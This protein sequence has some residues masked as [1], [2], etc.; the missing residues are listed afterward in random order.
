MSSERYELAQDDLEVALE[1]IRDTIERATSQGGGRKKGTLNPEDK[2]QLV[3]RYDHL[4]SLCIH[5]F[6]LNLYTRGPGHGKMDITY[7]I[8]SSYLKSI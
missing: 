3:T 5:C 1:E 7:F 4:I 2:R 8:V 6:D